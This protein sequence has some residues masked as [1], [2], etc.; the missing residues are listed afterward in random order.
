MTADC[1]PDLM[2]D[3]PKLP[4][5]EREILELLLDAKEDLY[6]LQIVERSHGRVSRGSVYVLLGRM[7]DRGLVDARVESTSRVP[8][9]PRQLYRATGLGERLVKLHRRFEAEAR[10]VLRPAMP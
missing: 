10:R 5:K 1:L 4:A 2:S 6:G 8:G 9:M 3:L 7:K